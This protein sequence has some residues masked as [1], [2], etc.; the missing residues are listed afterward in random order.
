MKRFI[1]LLLVVVIA[2]TTLSITAFAAHKDGMYNGKIWK[3]NLNIYN[4]KQRLVATF[5][6]AGESQYYLTTKITINYYDR[7]PRT[8][9]CWSNGYINWDATGETGVYITYASL[10]YIYKGLSGTI[11]EVA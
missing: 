5:S 8:L 11:S 7:Q 4:N 10:H 1:A 9:S 6:V 2:A 3:A